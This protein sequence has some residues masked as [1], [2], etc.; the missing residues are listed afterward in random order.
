MVG[1]YEAEF[2][3]LIEDDELPGGTGLD[4]EDGDGDD[5]GHAAAHRNVTS[6]KEAISTIVD[7][8][9]EARSRN[10]QSHGDH[11]NRGGRGRRRGK[12]RGG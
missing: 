2:L 12:P 5:A 7:T 1:G 9:L 4:D 10:P 3:P 6:W 11:G 8:N